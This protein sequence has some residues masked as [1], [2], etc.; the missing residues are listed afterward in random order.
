V[1]CAKQLEA[2]PDDAAERREALL[3]AGLAWKAANHRRDAERVWLLGLELPR[4]ELGPSDFEI[5][6]LRQL[7]ETYALERRRA[8]LWSM[9]GRV[10]QLAEPRQKHE[11]LVMRARYL[12]EMV[13]PQVASSLLQPALDIDPKDLKTRLAV[14]LYHLEADQMKE[15]RAQL[16][17][18]VQQAPD[19]PSVWEAWCSCLH[20]ARDMFA[21]ERAV[22][23]LPASADASAVCW[24]F[25]GLVAEQKGKL[26]EAVLALGRSVE[27]EPSEP[28]FHHR[29]GQLLVRTGQTAPG[30]QHLTRN[31]ELQNAREALREAMDEYRKSWT[32]DSDRRPEIAYR[33]GSAYENLGQV[34]ESKAWYRAALSEDPAHAESIA[35]LE[36]VQ[37][38][39]EATKPAVVP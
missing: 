13:D 39:S 37:N 3:G 15:A 19:E 11:P 26:D 8:E 23:Q 2:V 32:R 10:I 27:L 16:F 35:A 31:Q 29:L 20:K 5:Q 14:G 1:E 30:Q 17:R 25:R 24:K 7:C 34:E 22:G 38:A 33:F 12:F 4:P 36:R 21:L 18:C 9:T 6:C 28:E